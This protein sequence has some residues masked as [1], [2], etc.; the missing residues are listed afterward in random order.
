[1][2]K[3]IVV[4]LATFALV[5]C[6]DKA[7][8]N[9]PKQSTLIDNDTSS[10]NAMSENV[11]QQ[12]AVIEITLDEAKRISN[13]IHSNFKDIWIHAEDLYLSKN[14]PEFSPLTHAD[15]LMKRYKAF[16]TKN[17]LTKDFKQYVAQSCYLCYMIPASQNL[18]LAE[19]VELIDVD[20]THFSLKAH[21]PLDA[22]TPEA[23]VVQH[24]VLNKGIWKIDGE[25]IEVLQEADGTT[26]R[27]ITSPSPSAQFEEI[28][29]RGKTAIAD[30]HTLLSTPQ[31]GSMTDLLKRNLE[32]KE[33]LHAIVA[34]FEQMIIPV[35]PYYEI[36]KQF[37]TSL[38]EEA[39]QNMKAYKKGDANQET[40]IIETEV[41]WLADRIE[42]LYSLYGEYL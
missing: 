33:Q 40:Y 2:K 16:A 5:A 27:D 32:V 6:N 26:F 30:Y 34:E 20:E 4:S 3:L 41:K 17:F 38:Y 12:A 14:D 39:V 35:D 13:T 42:T 22:N 19:N 7:I 29:T 37:W 23:N 1:M 15:R 31:D 10:Q 18:Q 8:S 28:Y 11:V 25:E 36:N 9:E 21:V 24:F